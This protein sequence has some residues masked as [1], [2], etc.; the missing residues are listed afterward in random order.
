MHY[1][2]LNLSESASSLR[3][4]WFGSQKIFL[5]LLALFGWAPWSG[6][7]S[8]TLKGFLVIIW[9]LKGVEV[10]TIV[11]QS[12]S[13]VQIFVTPWT[14]THQDSQSFTIL[15][16]FAE[17]HVHWCHWWCHPIISHSVAPFS[18]PQS[19][20]A[21]G[22]FPMSWLFASGGLLETHETIESSGRQAP[23]CLSLPWEGPSSP[24]VFTECV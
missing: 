18:C 12:L 21:S 11:V 20:P 3:K 7:V 17:T 9:K 4:H 23:K 13:R 19:F 1:L 24:W 8:E 15:L 22:S 2:I 16:E 10:L 14:A 5:L 6:Q